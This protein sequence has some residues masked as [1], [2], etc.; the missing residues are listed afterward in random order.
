MLS[1]RTRLGI[2]GERVDCHGQGVG[3]GL[4]SKISFFGAVSPFRSVSDRNF[5]T[6]KLCESMLHCSYYIKGSCWGT[7]CMIVGDS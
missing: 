6:Q 3:D 7:E 5:H 2:F 4:E 1:L